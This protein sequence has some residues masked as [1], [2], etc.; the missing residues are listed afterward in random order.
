[1]KKFVVNGVSFRLL[2]QNFFGL[3]VNGKINDC[4]FSRLLVNLFE[5][6]VIHFQILRFKTSAV[7]NGRQNAQQS[8]IADLFAGSFSQICF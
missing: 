5:I 7:N 3:I 2:N 1:M 6:A 8:Q 4:I